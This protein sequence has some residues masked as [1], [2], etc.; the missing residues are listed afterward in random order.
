MTQISIIGSYPP[1]YGGISIHV[2]RLHTLM[3]KSNDCGVIDFYSDEGVQAAPGVDRVFGNKIQRVLSCRAILKQQGADLEHFHVSAMRK[4]LWSTPVLLTGRSKKKRV[5]TI[6]GGAFPQVVA[7]FNFL[8]KP[9]FKWMMGCFDHFVCV[10][11]KQRKVLEEWDIP[12]HKLS[13]INAYMPPVK[14]P[15]SGVFEELQRAKDSGKKTFVCSSMYLEHYGVEELLQVWPKIEEAHNVQ[16]ALLAY[17]DVDEG[18]REKCNVLRKA[19]TSVRE[20]EKLNPAL[21]AELME[22]SDVFIRPTWWDGDAISLR[23]AAFFGN[24]LIATDVTTRPDGAVL[25]NKKDT[26]S[27]QQAIETCLA[28][29]SAGLVNFDHEMSLRKLSQVYRQLGMDVTAA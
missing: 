18:Y 6:H 12:G 20:F 10:S 26:V 28:D 11:E 27:L 13:V 2:E 24:Q 4:F 15:V 1:N 3:A 19:T 29:N 25:C 16:L 5:L 21:V 14:S 8:E 7:S 22:L 23:E 9:L 17:G